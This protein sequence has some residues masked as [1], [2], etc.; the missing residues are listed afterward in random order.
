MVEYFLLAYFI[1][2]NNFPQNYSFN[3]VWA[4]Y[5]KFL[6]PFSQAGPALGP[7]MP[8]MVMTKHWIT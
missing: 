7:T 5:E 8:E 2:F 4:T 3:A 1:E 6:R